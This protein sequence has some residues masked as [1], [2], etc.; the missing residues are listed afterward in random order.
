MRMMKLKCLQ[1]EIP[2][3]E[4]QQYNI[5]M[6]V[7]A[8]QCDPLDVLHAETASTISNWCIIEPYTVKKRVLPQHP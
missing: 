2:P 6:A 4:K 3:L 1:S 7:H 8:L 5:L